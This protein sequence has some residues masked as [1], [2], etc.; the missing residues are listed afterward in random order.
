[1][2]EQHPMIEKQPMIEKHPMIELRD[3]SIGYGDHIV[4]EDV[5]L[6][7]P[8]GQV[9][10]LIGPNGSGKSSLLRTIPGL[11]KP[12]SG[13]IFV[14]G[15]RNSDYAGK[16]LARR[17]AYLPQSR[18]TPVITGRR[19]VRHGRFPWLSFP[20][21]LSESDH[22]KVDEAMEMTES[23]ELADRELPHLSGGQQQKL[24]LAMALAQDTKAILMDEPTTWLDIRHQ[25]AVLELARS[26]AAQGKAVVLVSHD[27]LQAFDVADQLILLNDRK[28]QYAG[29][30]EH[31]PESGLI[32]EHFGV[33]MIQVLVDG[34][35]R[36]VYR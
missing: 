8:R 21:R 22:Q 25:L 13:Q 1:M 6:I 31:L 29:A 15:Q 12:L 32:E 23:I 33:K 35:S 11:L 26:L 2:V 4:L 20:R 10:V 19:L 7:F 16:D 9:S 3:V 5:N 27:L 14:D 24:Y 28:V 36:Y 30:P 17:V 34:Y 18:R